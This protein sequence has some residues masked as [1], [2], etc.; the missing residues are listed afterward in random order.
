M[1]VQLGFIK[2]RIPGLLIL[3][4]GLIAIGWAIAQPIIKGIEKLPSQIPSNEIKVTSKVGESIKIGADIY[5]VVDI[6]TTMLP[7]DVKN[8]TMQAILQDQVVSMEE[9]DLLFSAYTA[10]KKLDHLKEIESKLYPKK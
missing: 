4:T 3:V 6:L 7:T 5:D 1:L 9:L 10:K 8:N 2:F